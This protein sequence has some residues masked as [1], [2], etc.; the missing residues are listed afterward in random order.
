MDV[1]VMAMSTLALRNQKEGQCEKML[2]PS[3]MLLNGVQEEY[4]SQ[5]EP[6]SKTILGGCAA[7]KDV[8]FIILGTSKTQEDMLFEYIINGSER[9]EETGKNGEKKTITRWNPGVKLKIS[10]IDFFKYRM[11]LSDLEEPDAEQIRRIQKRN[12]DR[13]EVISLEEHDVTP[14]IAKTVACI[15]DIWDSDCKLWIDTQGGFRSIA[16]V[17]NAIISLL[18]EDVIEPEAVYSINYEESK[19]NQTVINQKATYKIF[20]FVSGI[21][22][23][24]R[25]GRAEQLEDYYESIG[26]DVP[27]EIIQMKEIA[28]AIQ[29]CDIE[30]FD[31]EL[32]EFRK[33]ATVKKARAGFL[34]IFWNQIKEDYRDLLTDHYSGLDVVEWLYKKK[35]YQQAITYLE[36]KL[37]K[38]WIQI[39][40]VPEEDSVPELTACTGEKI[41]ICQI[42]ESILNK[43]DGKSYMEPENKIIEVAG[44]VVSD[45]KTIMEF[46]QEQGIS[47]E[48]PDELQCGLSKAYGLCQASEHGPYVFYYNKH[49]EKIEKITPDNSKKGIMNG[50]KKLMDLIINCTDSKKA[51]RVMELILL[52]KLLKNERNKFNHMAPNKERA[53][54]ELLG[55]VIKLFIEVGRSVAPKCEE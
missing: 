35:F 13:V 37:P 33:L 24:R 5:M 39:E 21:N 52:Y 53:D 44:H 2:L 47:Y 30:K 20:Q 17:I 9:I 50:S 46:R 41:V 22:E 26:E 16:L 42:K 25:Y 18:K 1:I 10:A 11:G 48:N 28:E 55:K 34:D 7:G 6:G 31:Q 45:H 51:V 43:R 3:R 40:V 54:Q 38:E 8:K 12:D 23:F 4:F 29:M 32:A 27:K 19:Q 36:A 15:R 49:P 14:A